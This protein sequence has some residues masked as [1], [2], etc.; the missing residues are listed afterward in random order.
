MKKGDSV[1]YRCL[2]GWPSDAVVAKV[3]EEP[4][5]T[6]SGLCHYDGS[7]DLNVDV[8]GK[9]PLYL[10]RIELVPVD[11]LAP[12]TCCRRDDAKAEKN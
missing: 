11:Q 3:R 9:D 7:L 2:A 10:T 12:G 5:K 4:P 1:I 6:P 8:G